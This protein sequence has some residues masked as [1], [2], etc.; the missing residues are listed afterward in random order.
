[1]IALVVLLFIIVLR[2]KSVAPVTETRAADRLLQASQ[3]PQQ[4]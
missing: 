4:T 1:M 3:L 2:R